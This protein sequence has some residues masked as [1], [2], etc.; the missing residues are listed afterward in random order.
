M[1]GLWQEQEKAENSGRRTLDLNVLDHQL[2][3]SWGFGGTINVGGPNAGAVV[4]GVCW[5]VGFWLNLAAPLRLP[6]AFGFRCWNRGTVGPGG[7]VRLLLVFS[8]EVSE[9]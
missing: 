9:S 7:G 8:A 1:Y 3:L 6:L 4:L 5:C 2:K